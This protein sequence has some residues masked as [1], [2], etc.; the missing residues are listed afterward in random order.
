MRQ[1]DPAIELRI[2]IIQFRCSDQTVDRC[3]AFSTS[4]RSREYAILS[5]MKILP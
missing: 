3:G 4:L 5:V 1:Y 2:E